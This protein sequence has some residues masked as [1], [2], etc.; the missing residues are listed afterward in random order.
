MFFS[1]RGAPEELVDHH[2]KLPMFAISKTYRQN[3]AEYTKNV[4]LRRNCFAALILPTVR[5]NL[6]FPNR[7]TR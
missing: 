1:Y 6:H 5:E 2:A 3:F 4:G 7:E